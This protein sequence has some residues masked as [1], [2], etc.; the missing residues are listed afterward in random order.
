MHLGKCSLF[1]S[2]NFLCTH[3]IPVLVDDSIGVRNSLAEVKQMAAEDLFGSFHQLQI[4]L[5]V[6]SP[7]INTQKSLF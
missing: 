6:R 4:R 3:F 2:S 5:P 7:L 1:K